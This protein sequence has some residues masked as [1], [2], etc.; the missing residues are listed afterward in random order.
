MNTNI[1]LKDGWGELEQDG[2]FYFRWSANSSHFA[3][4]DVPEN[5]RIALN[6]G[7]PVACTLIIKQNNSLLRI[8][9]LNP[10]WRVL[11]IDVYKTGGD[12]FSIEI[13]H[14]TTEEYEDKFGI[15]VGSIQIIPYYN[16]SFYY[17][18]KS[19]PQ[20][21]K[22]KIF[23]EKP[24]LSA[25]YYLWYFS[26]KGGRCTNPMQAAK[27]KEGY[28]R[29][30]LD[31]PQYPTLG[32]YMMNDPSVIEAHIDWA[33]DHGIDCFICN[34]EGMRGHR[35]FLSENLVHILQG[36]KKN[37]TWSA[38]K[39]P[40]SS[41]DSTGNSW[42]AL[43]QGWDSTGYSIRNL[44]R[45]KFSILF[46]SRLLVEKWPPNLKKREAWEAFEKAVI[47]C[48]ENFFCS[49]QWQRI[50]GK[51][52]IYI[53]ELYSWH[54]DT[55][56]FL[57]FRRFLDKCVQ[58]VNDPI[59]GRKYKG[60]YIVADVMFS[61]IKPQERFTCFDAITCYNPYRS[62]QSGELATLPEKW[63][64][65]GSEYFACQGFQDFYREY[66]QWCDENGVAM[67]PSVI[68]RYNDRAVRG[69]VDHYAFPP[70]SKAPFTD[71]NDAKNATLFVDNIKC[72]L[73]F[74]DKN[75]GMLNINSWNE[76]FEDTA[77]EPVGFFPEGPYPDYFGQG[78]NVG[79]STVHGRDMDVP[80]RIVVY[81]K[82]GHQWIDTPEYIK[83]AG[84]DLTQGYEW[85]CYG[86]DYLTA[87]TRL[88]AR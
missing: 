87:L 40:F 86:L 8:F 80:D 49:P 13:S 78:N 33:A 67:I 52:V 68:S 1:I 75:I 5:Y 79:T 57:E 26:E 44:E 15:M 59:T 4:K 31:P 76:W 14:F 62:W 58:K 37:G 71:I 88:F 9:S 38:G 2:E 25:Y 56:D 66:K 77:I 41:Q 74:V 10:G 19:E 48:A 20:K 42:D 53:Y 83:K 39:I 36:D 7:T 61:F 81:G 55:H 22:S 21:I 65:L 73:P 6:V 45:M 18:H 17:D 64:P 30:K 23:L 70:V 47:Y 29:A 16:N 3:V 51:P 34:W 43:S 82:H 72:A 32:E 24:F 46:E 84:I 28:L 35:K 27:W 11:F 85:P 50:D 63:K 12:E 54:G 69:A 60:L